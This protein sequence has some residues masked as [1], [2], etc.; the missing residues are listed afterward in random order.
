MNPLPNQ[1]RMLLAAVCLSSFVQSSNVS[2]ADANPA[3]PQIISGFTTNGLPLL[4]FPYP[5]AQAYTVYGAPE[6]GGP[7]TTPVPGLVSG[8]TFSVTNPG[9]R[10]FYRVSVTPMSSNALFSATV[11][12]RLTYGP[13]PAD[14]DR[15]ASIGPQQFIAEQLAPN[16]IVEDLDTAPPI[17]NTP[18]SGPPLTNWIRVSANGTTSNTNFFFYLTAPGRVYIDDVRL[19]VG[20]TPDVGP[21]LLVN[22]DFEDPVLTNGWR[23]A[24]IFSGSRITNS[25]TVNGQAAS[26]ANCLLLLGS[27]N[28]TGDGASIQQP[29]A[30]TNPAG[31][32]Y[33]LSFSYLPVW[34]PGS[35]NLTVRLSGTTTVASTP[36]PSSGPTPPVPPT[37]VSPIFSKLQSAAPPVS[38]FTVP[39]VQTTLADLRAYHKLRAIQSKRQL[40]EILVQF[41]ENHFTTEY[42]K[43]EDYLDGAYNNSITND[44]F[45]RNYAVDLEWREHQ[46]IRQTLLNPNCTFL[47]LLKIS[48]ESPTMIIYLDTILSTRNAPNE[49]YAR[50]ILEL[51]TMGAD[52]G[53]VQQDIVE[54]ARVWTGWSVAKKDP[55]N[56]GNPFAPTQPDPTNSPGLFSIHFRPTVHTTNQAKRLF[57]NV[58]VDTRFGPFRGGQSYALTIGT[59]AY[60]GTNG[61][62]EGYV[63]I[64]HLAN[65]PQTMEFLSVKLCQLFVHEDFEYGVYDYASPATPEAQLVKSCM[66][67]W[68]TPASDGR[69]GNIR[70][71]L[72]AIFSSALFRGHAA[73]Q[74]KIKTPL[75][76]AVSAIRA[77]Q[78]QNTDTNNYISATADTDGYALATPLSRMGGM[79]LFNKPE[80]DGFSEFGRNWMSTANLDERWRFAQHLLMASNYGLKNTD[81]NTRNNTSDPSALIRA[82]V[83]SSSWNDSGAIADFFLGLLYPGEG[84]ANLGQDRQAAIDFLNTNEQ[85]ASS[86]FVFAS[87]DGR[88]RGMVA[89]LMCF[90]RFQEQ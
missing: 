28:G 25:P 27:G 52:N 39:P 79:G 45:R 40:Y 21:N 70:S 64:N 85:G 33:T 50:E 19:V 57:T 14:I 34:N 31:T 51:H 78:T 43:I 53:Y 16:G 66:T 84:T 76:F 63:V 9:A 3:P 37:S 65:L 62:A 72:Q 74:Q 56:L 89:L 18:P 23:V 24:A 10:G 12:N 35:N 87:H 59:N 77:L 1:G 82:K 67:A 30:L 17:V 26:G 44:T 5:A 36:L 7:Y 54:L 71:V 49:N 68:D 75:E 60:P 4:S 80:P 69:K 47:D 6:V 73:S 13:S 38:Q 42:Q 8:P 29:Y 58:V 81:Y 41:F 32:R 86:P 22:G 55:S 2:A 83:P 61:F 11:L 46:K 15:I 90:P 20:N 48:I 88:V